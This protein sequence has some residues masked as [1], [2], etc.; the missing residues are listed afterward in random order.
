MTFRDVLRSYLGWCPGFNRIIGYAPKET[1]RL[2]YKWITISIAVVLVIMITSLILIG[3]P[4]IPI[5]PGS[6]L[7]IYIGYGP[8]RGVYLDPDFNQTFDYSAFHNVDDGNG[9]LFYDP[10]NATE[11]AKG[12]ETEITTYQFSTLDEV[13]NCTLRLDM[14]NAVRRYILWLISQD[15]NTTALKTL[16][17]VRANSRGAFGDYIGYNFYPPRNDY[18]TY[19]I[20]RMANYGGINSNEGWD[21]TLVLTDGVKIVKSSNREVA[22]YL[23]IEGCA[24]TPF[25]GDQRYRVRIVH[26]PKG[27]N[28]GVI[29][30]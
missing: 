27:N 24:E 20:T 5:S 10:T 13:Y 8:R 26:Y 9:P 18:V 11:Y 19:S 30:N 28:Y 21:G 25:T 29:I 14:P 15:Y 17:M 16:G 23:G 12:S 4:P 3:P 1:V 7:Q 22:W 6:P 2:N